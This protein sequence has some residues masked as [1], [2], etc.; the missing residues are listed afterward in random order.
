MSNFVYLTFT[1][2][3]PKSGRASL[4]MV[5]KFT[6]RATAGERVW[7]KKSYIGKPDP[8]HPDLAIRWVGQFWDLGLANR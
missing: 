4:G 2:S 6:A 3:Y 8:F 5:A 1:P 7:I